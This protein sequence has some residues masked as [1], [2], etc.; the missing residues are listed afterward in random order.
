MF[1]TNI[2]DAILDGKIDAARLFIN[3][4]CYITHIQKDELGA[5][6]SSEKNNR[7]QEL[8]K[9]LN[10]ISLKSISTESAVWDIS[11]WGEAKWT[12]EDNLLDDLSKNNPANVRDALIAETAIRNN[13]ILI[14]NDLKLLKKI[15][16]LG[17]SAITLEQ[18]CE[19]NKVNGYTKS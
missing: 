5:I 13:M 17:G 11:K 14:T 1:D 3:T 19:E 10:S 6:E 12:S 2:F 4:E 9:T 15:K 18:F 7:K 8:L 16:A